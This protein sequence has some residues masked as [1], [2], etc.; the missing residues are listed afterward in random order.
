MHKKKIF[1]A[2]TNDISTD[3]RVHKTCSFLVEKGFEVFVY[4][5]V[6][7]DTFQIEKSYKIFR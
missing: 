6:L 3:Y 4:G 5:R 7:P 2:V 1:V